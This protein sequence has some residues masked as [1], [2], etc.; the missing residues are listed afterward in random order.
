MEDGADTHARE[1]W[2][3]IETRISEASRGDTFA[4]PEVSSL[5]RLNA[6]VGARDIDQARRMLRLPAIRR[7]FKE[8]ADGAS[9]DQMSYRGFLAELLMAECDDRARH[10]C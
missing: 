5:T 8:M 3:D 6:V 1:R 7:Q 2:L 4:V 9:H 10:R